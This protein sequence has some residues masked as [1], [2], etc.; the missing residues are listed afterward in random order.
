MYSRNNSLGNGLTDSV[1][2]G[3]LS[4]TLYSDSDIETSELFGSNDEDGFV[5]F[6]SEEGAEEGQHTLLRA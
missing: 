6:V 5:D 4:T 2:L 3:H 1:E